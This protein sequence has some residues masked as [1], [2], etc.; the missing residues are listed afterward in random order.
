MTSS[1]ITS[2]A[3]VL[4][5]D[6]TSQH[7]LSLDSHIQSEYRCDIGKCSGVFHRRDALLRHKREVHETAS[8][9]RIRCTHVGCSSSFKRHCHLRE[10]LR[11]IH[12]DVLSSSNHP[13]QDSLGDQPISKRLKSHSS[14]IINDAHEEREQLSSTQTSSS[15][16]INPVLVF[17]TSPSRLISDVPLTG[18]FSYQSQHNSSS[19]QQS[20]EVEQ[21]QLQPTTFPSVTIATTTTTPTETSLTSIA[22]GTSAIATEGAS[23]SVTKTNPTVS[24][25]AKLVNEC[26][27]P[28]TLISIESDLCEP[29]VA[30]AQLSSNCVDSQD[31][32]PQHESNQKQLLQN[33]INDLL[34]QTFRQIS[35]VST[36]SL[37][38]SLPRAICEVLWASINWVNTDIEQSGPE[39]EIF[40]KLVTLSL[41]SLKKTFKPGIDESLRRVLKDHISMDDWYAV[42]V[43]TT[44]YTT[45]LDKSFKISPV[46][47]GYDRSR[48]GFMLPLFKNANTV[49]CAEWYIDML[50]EIR[51]YSC[52][53]TL[54]TQ[55]CEILLHPLDMFICLSLLAHFGDGRDIHP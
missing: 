21:Q 3:T 48:H 46:Q 11:N 16:Q 2:T 5:S 17:D 24:E 42:Q 20:T 43:L 36:N 22:T 27:D 23:T 13:Q 32:I 37:Y 49:A 51:N 9:T 29:L 35:L 12:N 33:F 30:K 34:H 19:N 15:P 8:I 38:E 28:Q 14:N 31:V 39:Q 50:V 44:S 26:S 54:G 52:H 7:D 47:C 41:E 53:H 25:S 10:H 1:T 6:T 18:H 4:A 40:Q 45:E 55:V